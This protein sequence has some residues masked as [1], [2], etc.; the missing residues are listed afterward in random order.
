[1]APPVHMVSYRARGALFSISFPLLPSSSFGNI[2][3][4][5]CEVI[6]LHGFV[7]FPDDW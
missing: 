3:H 5:S 2:L 1:M 7:H 4:K 6:L